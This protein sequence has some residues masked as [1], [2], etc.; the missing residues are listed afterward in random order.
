MNELT[1][2]EK[3]IIIQALNVVQINGTLEQVRHISEMIE[4]I[5]E[6]LAPK[7]EDAPEGKT[8]E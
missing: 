5:I 4:G 1:P 7:T 6:K 8:S 2:E 3:G